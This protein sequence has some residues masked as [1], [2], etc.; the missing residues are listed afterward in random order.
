MI[1]K[2]IKYKLDSFLK[3]QFASFYPKD[4]KKN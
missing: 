1:S 4:I 2:T 3:M